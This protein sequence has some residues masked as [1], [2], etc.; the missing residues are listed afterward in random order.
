MVSTQILRRRIHS[1]QGTAKICKAMEMIATA[2]MRRAQEQ[3]IAGRPYAEEI[4][5][6]VSD[7]AVEAQA[8]GK[9]HPLLQ[10][11]EIQKIAIIHMTTDRGLCGGLNDNQN[12]LVASFILEQTMPVTL[13]TI[14][15][16]GRTFARSAQRDLRAEFTGISDRPSLLETL[17]ISRVVIDDYSN[18]GVDLVYLAYPRFITTMVQRPTM[19]VLLPM[20]PAVLP[21]AQVAEYIYEPDPSAV[22]GELLPRYVEM[23]VY[24][25]ILELVASEQSARMVAMRNAS[26][27]AKE[28]IGDLTLALNKVRQEMI[29]KEICDISGGAEALA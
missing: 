3:A 21:R 4:S 16:K 1:V 18:G 19:E 14:G 29:T 2:K 17:P 20:E 22:L 23:K 6:V 25:A 28:L 11:R 15:R 8:S 10:K 26:D 9:V 13:V 5:K 24:H 7:L 27:N 12:R